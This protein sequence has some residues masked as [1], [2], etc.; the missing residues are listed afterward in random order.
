MKSHGVAITIS[1][2]RQQQTRE[3]QRSICSSVMAAWRWRN[4][5]NINKR[6][7]KIRR[8]QASGKHQ[9]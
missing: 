2:K 4:E 6:N 5:E 1:I 8:Q 3:M 7:A 9:Q